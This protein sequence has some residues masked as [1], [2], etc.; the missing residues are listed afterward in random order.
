MNSDFRPIHYLG[1]K[2]RLL[3]FIQETIDKLDPT[4]G[5]V[6]DLFAGS[7]VVSKRLSLTRPV[8]SNDIQEYSKIICSALLLP[9]QKIELKN[10]KISDSKIYKEL[11]HTFESLI[12]YEKLALN[13]LEKGNMDKMSEIMNYGS[14]INYGIA[15]AAN[16][17]KD[18][19]VAL[20]ETNKRLKDSNLINSKKTMVTRYYGGVYFSFLQAIIIDILLEI[21][22]K[23]PEKSKTLFHAAILSSA[24]DI[25]NTV[26]KQFAQP[27]TP[28]DNKGRQKL[29]LANKIL[30]DRGLDVLII[31]KK[32]MNIYNNQQLSKFNNV[33]IKLNYEDALNNQS[34]IKIVY[35]DPPY[36]RYHY[37]RYYHV[38][39]SISLR[40][41][42][43][44]K[45]INK[46]DSRIISKGVYRNDR[47][48][49]P[50]GLK[51]K[52]DHS[53]DTLFRK[54]SEINAS[55]VLSYSPYDDKSNA[56]PRT[57]T[58]NNLVKIANKYFKKVEDLSFGQFSHSK[59]NKAIL[60]IDASDN[61]E[62]LIVCKNK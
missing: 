48:Q 8:I 22:D 61:A 28:T 9:F 41:N 53:F 35:A 31:F 14:I 16:I 59:L 39:E 7:G 3:D 33:V 32:W 21:K 17:S 52:S 1:S 49:S 40:D 19:K 38:L 56:T 4:M 34:N 51:S 26:G 30:K 29:N 57:Q 25:V 5:V 18:F 36:T 55:L 10:I 23:L 47:H 44:I 15:N 46:N 54:T 20:D 12:Y 58:I 24:S 27:L 6:C 11:F 13:E 42:P 60:H 37:S 62:M 43:K 50:F 2:L 45:T